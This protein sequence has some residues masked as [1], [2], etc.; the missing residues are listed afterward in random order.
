MSTADATVRKERLRKVMRALGAA[1]LPPRLTPASSTAAA[2]VTTVKGVDRSTLCNWC[3]YH[4]NVGFTRLYLFFDAV[5][6]YEEVVHFLQQ[7]FGPAL[8]LI[9]VDDALRSSWQKLGPAASEWLPHASTE[10]QSRQALNA[11]HAMSLCVADGRLSWLLH[12]DLD[13]LWYP[14]PMLDAKAHFASLA[15]TACLTY[16]NLEAV[17]ETDHQPCCTA[18]PA[19]ATSIAFARVSLFKRNPNLID[20]EAGGEDTRRALAVWAAKGCAGS[21]GRGSSSNGMLPASHFNYYTNG[22]SIARVAPRTRP[23]SVHEW[24]PG[25]VGGLKSWYSCLGSSDL[26]TAVRMEVCSRHRPQPPT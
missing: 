7:R 3:T 24:L 23:L 9:A 25:W 11:L 19:S 20:R 13:E 21:S 1:E 16:T 2:I 10:V 18:E 12:I 22:K 6:E 14:G 8:I 15:E 26:V 17:P 5:V 4:L